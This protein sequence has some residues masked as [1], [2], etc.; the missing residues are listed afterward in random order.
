MT[1]RGGSGPDLSKQT[2]AAVDA[3]Y[4][5]LVR[6]AVRKSVRRLVPFVALL[7][8]V[9][10]LDR[11]NIAF[12]G[13]GGMNDALRL[14]GPMF[15]FASGIFFLG[16][17]LLEV[18]SNMALHRFGAR[19]WIARILVTWGIIASLVT[20]VP[21]AGTL[22]LLRFLLGVAEAGFFPG[23]ILYLTFW[24]PQ[25]ERARMTALFM[26]AVPLSTAIGSPLSSLL[27]E[28][29]HGWFGLDG[30]RVMF[31]V[32]GVPAVLL[33]VVTWF[34]LTD[35]P[36]AAR[37]LAPAERDALQRTLDAEQRTRASAYKVTILE[38]LTRPRVWALAFVYF[39]VVYGLYALGFFL[40]TIIAG[41]A[42]QYGAHY[43]I[44]QRG[45]INAIPYVIGAIAMIPWALHGDRTRERVWH[46]ALP[47]IVGGIAI[48]VALYLDSPF[49]AMVAVSVCAI[50]IMCALPTFW[51][52]PTNFLSGAAAASGIALINS[53]GN[54]AGFLAPYI[55]G[56]LKD[57]TGSQK[58]G[59]WAVGIAM[60]LAGV[61]A[62]A[63]RT[64]PPAKDES[65]AHEVKV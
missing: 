12:A 48:P 24:F 16:Y 39:G 57:G 23:I 34:F 25:R 20:F 59:L 50:G 54:S 32:E 56:W 22:Y 62:V 18:P 35:R 9:N 29:G 1:Q 6:S 11:T 53:V 10:Y 2:G 8:F 13:P 19:R 46:V 31:L 47:S 55:T 65:A 21:N 42:E 5:P 33:G 3:S 52:L 60:V 43:S 36:E 28:H 37:W 49:A 30:W 14:S 38:S 26:V 61:L 4:D 17:L 58:A 15:G 45:L 41:F 64:L 51:A 63:L 44:M 40:P 27:I 7:Y